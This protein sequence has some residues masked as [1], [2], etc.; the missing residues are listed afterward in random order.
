MNIIRCYVQNFGKLHEFEYEFSKGINIIN[1]ENGWGKS[2]LANFIKAMFYGFDNSN[3]RTISE[4]E[5]KRYYPWQGEKYG[6][7][8]EFEIN[9]K[10]YEIERFFGLKDKDDSFKL[11]DKTTNME[12]NDY[13]Q[14]IGEEIFKIDR[15]A[16]ER[17]T[18]IPQ[19]DIS[20]E[21]ND[22]LS[23][24]LSNILEGENDIN[25]SEDAIN[26]II[27][28]M[29]EY[30]KT[31]NR[32][33]I[34]EIES[35]LL[36]KKRKLEQANKNEE[37]INERNRRIDEVKSRIKELE[38]ERNINQE[39]INK[40]FLIHTE[41]LN[42]N[43]EINI[44]NE[45]L[46]S[47]K[48]VEEIEEKNKKQ[49][50]NIIITISILTILIGIISG[51]YLSKYLYLIILI[52]IFLFIHTLI[53]NNK[54]S[55]EIETRDIQKQIEDKKEKIKILEYEISQLLNNPENLTNNIEEIKARNELLS[56][57]RDN[58]VNQKSYDE[59]ELN[60]L[61]NTLETVEE[62]ET[63]VE[64]LEE[65]QLELNKKYNILD[66]TQK[67][68]KKAKEQFSS[69]YL[70]GMTSGFE[71]YLN[72]INGKELETNIDVKLNVK[73]KSNGENKE[74]EYFSTGYKDLIGISIRFALIDALF[75]NEKPFIILDDPFVNLDG[76]KI[77]KAKELIKELSKEYQIIYFV[78]HESRA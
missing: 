70:Q 36:A 1:A 40:Y 12:S 8:L 37:L 51:I 46:L 11:Y 61:I 42:I 62:I 72:I 6:G 55:E 77:E 22:S 69:H 31:G 20:V 56:K 7:S 18:Y 21:I 47:E 59:N 33:K 50:I 60:R 4:N 44:L 30:K 66:K 65:K 49:K 23:A 58:L 63:E 5:R 14:N 29:K 35:Q 71:K 17:S 64:N 57:E 53:R 16:Y 41:I 10:T 75:E 26:R 28:E 67:Y 2:T 38:N 76:E 25:S 48:R 19:Q 24:K 15:Q 27:L 39:I 32:G 73:I 68:L 45:K 9:G 52:G 3:K 34:N 54:K 43:N 13:S 78:C 74:L